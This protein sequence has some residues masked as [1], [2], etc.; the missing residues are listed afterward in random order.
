MRIG[1]GAGTDG[2]DRDGITAWGDVD[3]EVYNVIIDHNSVAWSVDENF[4]TWDDSKLGNVHD[5]TFSWNIS[6]EAL[7]C[8]IH[9]D[10]GESTPDCHSMGFLVGE[11]T[12]KISIHHN[13]LAS[14]SDRNPRLGGGTSGEFVNNVIYNWDSG[15]TNITSFA[16]N[17]E[18][19]PS[20]NWD[21]IGNYYKETINS[22][23]IQN[24]KHGINIECG[25]TGKVYVS[26]NV[27][28][29]RRLNIG[30]EWSVVMFA[31][32]NSSIK[33]RTPVASSGISFQPV[34]KAYEDVLNYAGSVPRDDVDLRAINTTHD[35]NPPSSKWLV[36]SPTE[37]G[38][39]QDYPAGIPIIDTDND[40][41]PNVWEQAHGLDPNNAEDSS[42]FNLRAP[43]GYTWIEE[44]INSLIPS[45]NY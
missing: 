43:S 25:T 16:N 7:N 20:V 31:C 9:I 15:N 36:D 28:W 29:G 39:M 35:G 6:T 34:M 18:S 23:E 13:L 44:Y 30:D 21:I 1:D 2:V 24:A 14:N 26:G 5:L 41:I 37:V 8:G 45:P 17:G 19:F 12:K 3:F 33:S 4:S 10:E 32:P 42:N 27:G 38:G 22:N 11:W 40:G